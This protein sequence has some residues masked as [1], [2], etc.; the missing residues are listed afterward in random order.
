MATLSE[1][2]Q[3]SFV[4][5][6][7][8]NNRTAYCPVNLP[9]V[10][11]VPF[12]QTDSGTSIAGSGVTDLRYFIE[13]A[14]G[15]AKVSGFENRGV[16]IPQ[17]DRFVIQVSDAELLEVEIDVEG[18]Q[19]FDQVTGAEKTFADANPGDTFAYTLLRGPA[20]GPGQRDTIQ[21]Y[22]DAKY[23]DLSPFIIPTIDLSPPGHYNFVWQTRYLVREV[24]P[25]LEFLCIGDRT[26]LER[27]RVP[28]NHPGDVHLALSDI[29][30]IYFD[31]QP[32]DRDQQFQFL[33]PFADILQDVMDEQTFLKQINWIDRIPAQLIPYLS[34][35]VGWELPYFPGST[36]KIR[37]TILKNARRLQGLK[38]SRRALIELFEFYGF[39]IDIINLWYT[40][41]GEEYI[42]PGE[43]LEGDTIGLEQVCQTEPILNDYQVSGFG[44]FEVPLLYRAEAQ[45][46]VDT[47]LVEVGGAA[48]DQ[49]VAQLGVMDLEPDAFETSLC[50][51]NPA[52]FIV[53]EVSTTITEPVV[54]YSRVLVDP[55]QGGIDD[56]VI[57]EGPITRNNLQYDKDTNTL[58][59]QFDHYLDLEDRSLAVFSIASY[60][61]QK[62]VVPDELK[63]LRSNRFDIRVLFRNGAEPTSE[64][65]EFLLEF[66]LRLKAFHS[67]LRKLVITVDLCDVYNVTDF[68]LGGEQKQ[69]EG[70]DAGEL[71]ASPGPVIPTSPDDECNAD[72]G[73][74]EETLSLRDKIISGLEAE[75]AAW[76]RLDGTREEG[77]PLLAALERVSR[78]ESTG[79]PCE[80]T[81][82]G[83]HRVI[84]ETE[85]KLCSLDGNSADYCYPG[86]VQ[87]PAEITYD[88]IA[89]DTVRCRPCS[90]MY[91]N[92]V[93][94]TRF[95]QP[96]YGHKLM[97]R[98]VAIGIK[99]E[100]LEFTNRRYFERSMLEQGQTLQ[101]PSLEIE[102]DNHHFPG[103]RF[104]SWNRVESDFTSDVW[105]FRPYDA[106]FYDG[107]ENLPDGAPTLD[108][109][110]PRLEMNE[111]G[112]LVLRFEALPYQVFSNSL[113]PDISSFGEHDDRS[114]TVTHK[115]YVETSGGHPA[116]SL[117]PEMVDP[118]SEDS[119][120]ITDFGALFS[121][122]NT[123]CEEDFIDGYPAETGRF[124]DTVEIN[125][126]SEIDLFEIFPGLP[127]VGTQ[128]DF[129]FRYNSGVLLSV[130]D[131]LWQHYKGWRYDCGCEFFDC[132]AD[133][134][135]RVDR[136]HVDLFEQM[137][138][139]VPDC[140]QVELDLDLVMSDTIGI[141]S[142][143]FDGTIPN[144]LCFDEDAI[145]LT[146]SEKFPPEG[147]FFFVDSYGIQYRGAFEVSGDRIDITLETK[148]PRVPGQAPQGSFNGIEVFKRGLVTT[149]RQIVE[150]P[151]T[152]EEDATVIAE[153]CEQVVETFKTNFTCGDERPTDPFA[154]KYSCAVVD[155]LEITTGTEGS[156]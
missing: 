152:S 120:S 28:F 38:G 53:S 18:Q 105:G 92:G 68:C 102:K 106:I 75:H 109:L 151:A 44:G 50:A 107:P 70:T 128:P 87:D 100:I 113:I 90:L 51:T 31:G 154:F 80:F 119:I 84:Q 147:S 71:Q 133:S 63:N 20:E 52:G 129:L 41:N 74:T 142:T 79:T 122:A 116:I 89:Q 35:L 37:R 45:I 94:W 104:L 58:N 135:E 132:S 97:A 125:R 2:F 93:Y 62:I 65:Y 139:F 78:N 3:P 54:G 82:Y 9:V 95:A 55:V 153:G 131:P 115:I 110:N 130:T 150:A 5:W 91:G 101:R 14:P 111:N 145:E 24:T 148:D 126:G 99:E 77:N 11:V 8:Q 103:H 21:W 34:Y 127:E 27:Y 123:V 73:F 138:Q 96:E 46:T 137:G 17:F 15:P 108:D 81:A 69:A 25:D 57:G 140:D 39:T 143:Q 33:R 43:T 134:R 56:T 12:S 32:L 144:H 59:V 7:I 29:P 64:L 36:D 114:F 72:R 42:A 1:R 23:Y 60:Q 6:P 47:W 40:Q 83:Q 16:F 121:S 117:D 136:C 67:L 61:R 4:Q 10:L 85:A 30:P 156:A 155:E 49:L 112:D 98:Y 13:E 26:G 76:Q 48:Y 146:V 124:T 88:I 149:L 66:L 22:P 141:C 19:F 86:R 118:G